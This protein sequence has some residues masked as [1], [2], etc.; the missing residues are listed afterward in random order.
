MKEDILVSIEQNVLRK[1]IVKA[2]SSSLSVSA[3]I[4]SVMKEFIKF[5]GSID[6]GEYGT[7]AP[8][9]SLDDY[10]KEIERNEI[11]KALSNT[12]TKNLAADSLGISFRSLRHRLSLF[13][14]D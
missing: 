11:K 1:L 2:E 6:F 13:E 14:N 10:L 3:L 12:E 9:Q 5:Q 8:E 7:R 4:E